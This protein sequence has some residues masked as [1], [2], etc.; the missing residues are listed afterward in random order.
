MLRGMRSL[1]ALLAVALSIALGALAAPVE[2]EPAA[3]A[4]AGSAQ[5][6]IAHDRYMRQIA[7]ALAASPRPRDWS[8]AALAIGMAGGVGPAE[9]A[10]ARER[11]SLLERAHG[12]A[13]QD[14][15]VL[16]QVA[17]NCREPATCRA[18]DAL[19]RL[20]ELEPENAAVWA[21]SASRE[22]ARAATPGSL[23]KHSATVRAALAAAAGASRFDMHLADV[24]AESLAALRK[25]PVDR[26]FAGQ[27]LSPGDG[28]PHTDFAVRAATSIG[29]AIA[30]M[31][32]FDAP[33]AT[34]CR[35]GAAANDAALR[36]DCIAY[37]GLLARSDG[38]LVSPRVGLETLRVLLAGTKEE[39]A[40]TA[41]LRRLDW[42]TESSRRPEVS[43]FASDAELASYLE[44]W[45]KGGELYAIRERMARAGIPLEPP[46][47][48]RSRSIAH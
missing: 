31:I 14:R 11:A 27:F 21:L 39:A 41:V 6:R 1:R 3:A 16:W 35:S 40:N 29:F 18:D 25:I 28:L 23:R 45:Q 20:Q 5:F 32:P 12:A 38:D 7:T 4:N 8:L 17:L 42:L 19:A 36:A 44:D 26:D 34:N 48:F 22:Q 15:F 9:S 10:N 2:L 43:S 46:A 13:P 30:S 24:L 37:S 47:E 33:F